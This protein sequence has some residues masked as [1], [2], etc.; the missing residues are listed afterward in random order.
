MRWCLYPC[1]LYFL[2]L[3]FKWVIVSNSLVAYLNN[4]SVR[5]KS[6]KLGTDMHNDILKKKIDRDTSE[7]HL[8][9]D[10]YFRISLCIS[11]PSFMFFH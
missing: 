11:V 3:P 9:A 10:E 1:S 8:T 7:N 4:T 6:M 5:V 2:T